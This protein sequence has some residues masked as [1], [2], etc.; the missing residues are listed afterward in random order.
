MIFAFDFFSDNAYL[1]TDRSVRVYHSSYH[2][3]ALVMLTFRTSRTRSFVFRM[4]AMKEIGAMS[5]HDVMAAPPMLMGR[6]RTR[7]RK[8]FI[9]QPMISSVASRIT[10]STSTAPPIA[11]PGGV[12]L[13]RCWYFGRPRQNRQGHSQG[14]DSGEM[15][16]PEISLCPGMIRLSAT[17][18][19][20]IIPP[21]DLVFIWQFGWQ[22]WLK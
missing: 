3:N 14:W 18:N 6:L 2:E 4:D 5:R 21:M 11:R 17:K 22:E 8:G 10:L 1:S 15:S 9:E 7:P 20:Y 19:M 12:V 13:N 16:H